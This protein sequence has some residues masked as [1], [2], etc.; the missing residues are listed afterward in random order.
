[1]SKGARRPSAPGPA[2]QA[3]WRPHPGGAPLSAGTA[4]MHFRLL[5][6]DAAA[7]LSSGSWHGRLSR[8]YEHWRALP[9]ADGALPRFGSLQPWALAPDLRFLASVQ[10]DFADF[11]FHSVGDGIAEHFGPHLACACLADLF[12]GAAQM[13]LIAAHRAC[14]GEATPVLCELS[15]AELDLSMRVPFQCLLLPFANDGRRVDRI[16]WAMAFPG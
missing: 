9:R 8:A 11:R 10:V 12:V 14:V 3:R 15:P 6:D 5:S 7:I 16:L 1:M 13:D 4:G 2:S